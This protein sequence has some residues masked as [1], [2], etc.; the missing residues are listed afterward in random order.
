MEAGVTSEPDYF[1]EMF[2]TID[3]EQFCNPGSVPNL[4]DRVDLFRKPA[5][6]A[7]STSR[8]RLQIS[9]SL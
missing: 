2:A 9:F 3:V 1:A 5:T 6:A 8:H 4:T 7:A